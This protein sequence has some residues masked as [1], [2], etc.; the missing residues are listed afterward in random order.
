MAYYNTKA[1][2][3]IVPQ[4]LN[5]SNPNFLFGFQDSTTAP[6]N[7]YISN[8]NVNVNTVIAQGVIGSGGG[9]H[10]YVTGAPPLPVAN[11]TISVFGTSYSNGNLNVNSGV[12]NSANINAASGFGNIVYQASGA[13]A[14]A[15]VGWTSQ[16]GTIVVQPYIYPDV[17]K[18][19]GSQEFGQ[20]F[21]PDNNDSS[22]S[23]FAD[24]CFPSSPVNCNV[25]LQM[26]SI[27]TDSGYSNVV[28]KAGTFIAGQVIGNV[29]TVR[30]TEFNFVPGKFMRLYVTDVTSNANAT[31]TIVGSVFA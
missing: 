2:N 28:N 1:A 19:G 18:I 20:K 16:S 24:I 6:F 17:L 5:G 3:K 8:I 23:F 29:Q 25:V 14:N 7:F 12:I 30:G 10:D 22:R 31:S 11:A 9:G 15:N 21:S 27:N 4:F 26:A 13:N